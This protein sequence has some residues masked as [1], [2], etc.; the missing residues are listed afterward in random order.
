MDVAVLLE[1]KTKTKTKPKPKKHT[2]KLIIHI[3]YIARFSSSPHI[4]SISPLAIT[5]KR[6]MKVVVC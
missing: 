4:L 2:I 6:I 1:T 5:V 3:Q